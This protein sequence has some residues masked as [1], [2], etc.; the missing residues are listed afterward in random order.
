MAVGHQII[1]AVY[2]IIKNKESY[3]EP[4]LHNNP[5]RKGKQIK[6]C[7][8][9]LKELG[10]TIEVKQIAEDSKVAFLLE[11]PDVNQDIPIMKLTS[12]EG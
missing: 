5:K 7:L 3:R 12:L 11:N 10:L 9:K 1:V 2:F 6:K 4:L 8:A